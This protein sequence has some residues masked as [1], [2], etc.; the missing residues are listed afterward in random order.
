MY[1][2]VEGMHMSSGKQIQP[3]II[4]ERTYRRLN[5]AVDRAKSRLYMQGVLFFPVDSAQA[6]V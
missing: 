1:T 6:G 2:D 3:Q 5:A 4:T